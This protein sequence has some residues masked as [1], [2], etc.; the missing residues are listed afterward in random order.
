MFHDD[1]FL[2][3]YEDPRHA[4]TQTQAAAEAKTDDLIAYSDGLK[5]ALLAYSFNGADKLQTARNV[6]AGVLTD[7]EA[8]KWFA[9]SLPKFTRRRLHRH[10]GHA[11]YGARGADFPR[12]SQTLAQSI[13]R[14]GETKR[15]AAGKT[16]FELQA[17]NWRT[18]KPIPD[19]ELAGLSQLLKQ[20]AAAGFGYYP[21]DFLNDRPSMQALRPY[22][23][24][25]R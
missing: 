22:F 12:R 1:G 21:D 9:Q 7:A 16:L 15:R 8:E 13:G 2:T 3:D 24:L 6:Y 23:S 18:Q 5:Q 19:A 4:V 10:H 17:S 11:L 20:E 14:H 25:R